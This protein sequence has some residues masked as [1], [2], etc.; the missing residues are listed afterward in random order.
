MIK[1][2]KKGVNVTVTALAAVVAFVLVFSAYGGCIDPRSWT[3][4]SLAVL[5]FPA[6]AVLNVVCLAV[7]LLLR[8]RVASFV[9]GGALLLS[10]PAVRWNMPMSWSSAPTDET[11]AFT[12]MTWNVIGFEHMTNNAKE[13]TL[14]HILDVDADVVVLQETS[15]DGNDFTKSPLVKRLREKLVKAYPYRSNPR[16]DVCLLSKFPFSVVPETTMRNRLTFDVPH[17]YGKIFDLNINGHD[18][19][20]IGLHMQSIGLTSDDKLLFKKVVTGQE[21]VHS[22]NQARKVKHSLIDKLSGAFTRRAGEA[23]TVRAVVEKSPENL[24]VCGDFNDVPGSYSYRTV[25]GDMNDAYIDCA[26]WPVNTYNSNG[27]YYRIDHMFYRGGFKAVAS[28]C[29]KAGESDHYPI[30]TTFEWKDND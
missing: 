27:F 20:I 6:V 15:L 1:K 17:T 26:T 10:L 19:R 13:T 23:H 29:D 24:I 22:K 12:V 16:A 8:N 9:L 11:R 2:F 25:R 5:A 4:P 28:R 3:L 18:L 21:G 14:Q 7:C 30:I